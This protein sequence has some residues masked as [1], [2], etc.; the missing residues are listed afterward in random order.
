MVQGQNINAVSKSI[1]TYKTYN[2]YKTA[3]VRRL[4]FVNKA[5]YNENRY[6]IGSGVGAKS[7]FVRL[8]LYQNSAK[9]SC[10]CYLPFNY[11]NFPC[12]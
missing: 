8:A 2:T 12:K 11:I 9:P 10:K 3:G 1:A 4:F 6:I 7:A 5:K